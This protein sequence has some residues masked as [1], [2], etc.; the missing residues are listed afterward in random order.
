MTKP[1]D[2]SKTSHRPSPDPTLR[3]RAEEKLRTIEAVESEKLSI[4]KTRVVLHELRVHQIEL[5]MQ[6]EELRKT[7]TALEIGRAR[8]F[9]LYDLAPVGYCTLSAKGIILTAN[10]TAA[11]MLGTT[12][13]A[14][15]KSLFSSF[16]HR[17]DE[18]IY[19][20][21]LKRL[22]ENNQ[23]QVCELRLLRKDAE[24]FWALLESIVSRDEDDTPVCRM[25]ISDLTERKLA[26]NKLRESER[27]LRALAAKLLLAHEEERKKIAVELHDS[28][29]SSL[30]A[31]K[32]GIEN[33]RIRDESRSELLDA[34]LAMT[35]LAIDEVRNIMAELRPLVL[36]DFGVITALN[37]FFRQYRT[38]YPGVHVE[39][40]T[41]IEEQDIPE[42][43]RI[44]IFRIAQEAFNNIAKYSRA[45]YADFRLVRQDGAI[46]LTIED[47]GD[48]F[49]LDAVLSKIGER[50]GLGLTSMKERA[51]LSGGSFTI[52]SVPGTGTTLSVKWPF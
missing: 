13:S 6:N 22:L 40:E 27:Q 3:A 41:C 34:P 25:V 9:D 44:V 52:R 8:Y 5:E 21:H 16:I 46:N 33:A 15:A 50:Q 38:T 35:Q 23:R 29:G 32:V 19:Y 43:L 14:L 26:E 45:E 7:Q 12:R 10:L 37:W 24:P 4:E 51:E 11:T 42:A 1:H 2:G 48:G 20:L 47:N 30:S 49:D 31:I 28:I 17:D 18:D 36:D 39:V